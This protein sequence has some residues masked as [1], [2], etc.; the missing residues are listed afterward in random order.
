M[1]KHEPAPTFGTF[2]KVNTSQPNQTSTLQVNEAWLRL[3]PPLTH[4][5]TIKPPPCKNFAGNCKIE[6]VYFITPLL[7]K[8]TIRLFCLYVC[9]TCNFANSLLKLLQVSLGMSEWKLDSLLYTFL[10]FVP[11]VPIKFQST[12]KLPRRESPKCQ[13]KLNIIAESN[14]IFLGACNP[15]EKIRHA[16][17]W[18]H[19][20]EIHW[21]IL[22]RPSLNVEH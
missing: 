2:K 9:S 7:A 20:L 16:N 17:E 22:L 19:Y 15:S 21:W 12:Q 11:A 8:C 13:Q 18:T 3:W 6:K 5:L 4:P 1:T 10:I 14:M